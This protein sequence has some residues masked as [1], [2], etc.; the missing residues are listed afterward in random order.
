MIGG[1]VCGLL[2]IWQARPLNQR[3]APLKSWSYKNSLPHGEHPGHFG[4]FTDV[5]PD[6]VVFVY[7]VDDSSEPD[8]QFSLRSTTDTEH[9]LD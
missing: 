1:V 3:V 6:L 4:P 8:I 7:L 9:D 2:L 5:I